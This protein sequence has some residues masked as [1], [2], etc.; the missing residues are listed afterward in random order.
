MSSPLPVLSRGDHRS[1]WVRRH[2]TVRTRRSSPVLRGDDRLATGGF[3]WGFTGGQLGGE[4]G[5]GTNAERPIDLQEVPRYRLGADEQGVRH[6][7]ERV[8]GGSLTRA[9]TRSSVGVSTPGVGRARPPIRLNSARALSHHSLAPSSSN[10]ARASSD[11]LA[12][13]FLRFRRLQRPA[14]E[15]RAPALER[16]LELLG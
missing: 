2:D 6:L 8:S 14:Y 11:N 15:K 3:D 13:P 16:L 5:A 9:A 10:T 4:L 7:A 12:G 1:L